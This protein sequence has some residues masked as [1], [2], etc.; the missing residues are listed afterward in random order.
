MLTTKTFMTREVFTIRENLSV[1]EAYQ[2]MYTRNIRHLPVLDKDDIV[3]GML[4]DRDVQRAMV[5][6]GGDVFL[7]S[8]KL[9]S[10]FMSP[11]A[12]TALADTPLTVI[13]EEM[14]EKKISAV[15]IVD[16]RLKCLGILTSHDVLRIFL[17]HLERDHEIFEKPISFFS[18]NTLF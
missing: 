14:M 2:L 1:L 18:S 17:K 10:E 11:I 12:F 4:S 7:N 13:M 5:V 8:G 6:N 15:V 16:E 9:V 3:I